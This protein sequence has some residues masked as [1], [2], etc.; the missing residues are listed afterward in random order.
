[1]THSLFDIGKPGMSPAELAK[2]IPTSPDS[3][4]FG[5]QP[6]IILAVRLCVWWL[7]CENCGARTIQQQQV[8]FRVRTATGV[9][10]RDVGITREGEIFVERPDLP[11]EIEHNETRGLFCPEC[12]G[13]KE[14]NN[15]QWE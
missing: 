12:W 8:L 9:L 6:V 2:R 1:M 4:S 13:G 10:L 5:S 3:A 7:D 15:K 11:R 14:V